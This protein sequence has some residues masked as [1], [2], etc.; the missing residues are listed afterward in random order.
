MKTISIV[1]GCYN[2]EENVAELIRKV[3]EVMADLPAYAYEHIFIDNCSEDRTVAIL[4]GFAAEDRRIKIIVNARN[5]GHIRSPY[6]ALLQ[7][8]GDAVICLAADFQD[9]PE[10][11]RDFVRKWEEGFKV[12]VGVKTRSRE[13]WW[14]YR[15]R[16]MYYKMIKRLASIEILE[17][18]T[19]FGLYDHKMIDILRGLREP[20]PYFRGLI[21]D[22]GFNIARIEYTQPGRRH[23]KTKNNFLTLFD[24]AMLGFTNYS[25]IPLRLATLLGFFAAGCSLLVGLGYLIAKLLFWNTFSAGLAPM[26]IGIFFL[27]SIQLFFLGVVGEY[28][29]ATF[30]YVQNRPLVIEKE[31]INFEE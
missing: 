1:T 12:V 29:G 17:H 2:E 16:S 3:R 22:I 14:M 25:K 5:F 10:M 7:T 4:K 24:I 30:T 18:F 27:G 21:S 31:R 15:L 6:H 11:I 28:V 23:G 19:G 9:P 13:G 20:Y 26:M 8:H